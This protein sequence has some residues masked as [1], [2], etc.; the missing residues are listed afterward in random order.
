MIRVAVILQVIFGLIVGPNGCCC[1]VQRIASMFRNY[2]EAH[3]IACCSENQP[4]SRIND[5]CCSQRCC[6][7]DK[8]GANSHHGTLSSTGAVCS[9]SKSC[10]CV[11]VIR[12]SIHRI[13][14]DVEPSLALEDLDASYRWIPL[15]LKDSP[16]P[17]FLSN[18]P[19]LSDSDQPGRACAVA[20]QRWNC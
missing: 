8:V 20:Y 5:S 12:P 13:L 6:T 16:A 11:A 1:T 10:L 3:E 14:S 7:T 18:R 15:E 19:G 2:G 4:D 17:H 9:Q